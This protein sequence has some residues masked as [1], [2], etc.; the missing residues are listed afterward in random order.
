MVE[1]GITM[2]FH[3]SW[4]GEA[5][6]G[7][8]VM[9]GKPIIVFERRAHYLRPAKPARFECPESADEKQETGVAA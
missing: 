7:A 1:K 3:C 5:V 2:S 4:C 8:P 9:L 6:E